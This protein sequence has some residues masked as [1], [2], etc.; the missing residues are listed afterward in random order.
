M[1]QYI[2]EQDDSLHE[3]Y[4]FSLY[5]WLKNYS[6]IIKVQAKSDHRN[7]SWWPLW[8]KARL[9]VTSQIRTQEQKLMATLE[10]YRSKARLLRYKRKSEVSFLHW[11]ILYRLHSQTRR[12]KNLSPWNRRHYLTIKSYHIPSN[13]FIFN[14][15]GAN[16]KHVFVSCDLN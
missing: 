8:S 6:T 4:K 2:W 9:L 16:Q 3:N 15:F 10:V 1:K 13:N 7:K 11:F 14:I 12:T 5:T